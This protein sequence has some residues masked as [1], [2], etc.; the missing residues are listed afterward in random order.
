MTLTDRVVAR[1][2]VASLIS[3]ALVASLAVAPTASASTTVSSSAKT[4]LAESGSSARAPRVSC[5]QTRSKAKIKECLTKYLGV[6]NTTWRPLVRA[7]GKK[8]VAPRMAFYEQN[9]PANPCESGQDGFSGGSFYCAKNKTIYMHLQWSVADS[10]IYPQ[11]A[12]QVKGVLSADSKMTKTSR[13]KLKKGYAS[14]RE[15]AILAHEY[16]HHVQYELGI[17]QWF[18]KRSDKYSLGSSKAD[19]YHYA[20]ETA[21]DCMTGVGLYRASSRKLISFGRLGQWG[22]RTFFATSNGFNEELPKRSPFVYS[23]AYKGEI[24]KGY[25][26]AYW[27]LRAFNTGQKVA[28]KSNAI[29]TCVSSA[30]KWKKVPYPKSLI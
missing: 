3:S 6:L 12:A 13:N 16:S 24:Y 23:N 22:A 20:T 14:M 30:A 27:R 8:F 28:K 11:R 25:G 26:E 18:A 9:L 17:A 15:A 5:P 4:M 1:G 7:K 10:T 2:A 21:A 19:R 29:K